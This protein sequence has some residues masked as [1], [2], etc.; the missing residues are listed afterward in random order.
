MRRAAGCLLALNPYPWLRFDI[1]RPDREP[2]R[3]L[4]HD[5]AHYTNRKHAT[6]CAN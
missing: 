3:D 4:A 1:A 5:S 6:H 2:P